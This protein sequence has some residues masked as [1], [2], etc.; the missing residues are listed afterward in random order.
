METESFL[1]AETR[2]L[3]VMVMEEGERS[4][5]TMPAGQKGYR[6]ENQ[7]LE[8]ESCLVIIFPLVRH[9]T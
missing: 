7:T 9:F 3:P 5:S 4:S 8:L 6:L 2:K 1:G